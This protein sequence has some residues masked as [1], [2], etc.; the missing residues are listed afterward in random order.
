MNKKIFLIFSLFVFLFGITNV[1]AKCYMGECV[2]NCEGAQSPIYVEQIDTLIMNS[3]KLEEVDKSYCTNE[4]NDTIT[5]SGT[6]VACG[7]VSGIPEKVP[8]ITSIVILIAEVAVPILL[9]LF[10]AFDF[11]KGMVSAK[12]DDIIGKRKLFVKRLIMGAMVFF[13][14]SGTKLLTSVVTDNVSS[15]NISNCI[16]CFINNDC[17]KSDDTETNNKKVK[18]GTAKTSKQES[19]LSEKAEKNK[20][21]KE[22]PKSKTPTDTPV[23]TPY[24]AD[25]KNIIEGPTYMKGILIVNKQYSIPSSYDTSTDSKTYKEALAAIEKLKAGAKAAGY[26]IWVQSGYRSYQTQQQLYNKYVHQDGKAEADRYSA[27]PGHS[28][29][30]TG[31]AYDMT[32]DGKLH[33]VNTSGWVSWLSNHCA[34]YGF[35]LRY[36][37]G[38]ESITGFRAENWHIRYVGVDHAKAM[39]NNGNWITLEEYVGLA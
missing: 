22:Q 6:R 31:L 8:Q 12:D 16:E 34:D 24:T 2:K 19:K 32:N 17:A 4:D 20:S 5:S 9:V 33:Y 39:Y 14:I 18:S 26:T 29:H 25:Y 3:Y 11:V 21:S 27:R 23:T 28:E 7:N 37:E 1:S 35:I 10:G 13:I 36:P 15:S 38:K 30:Q